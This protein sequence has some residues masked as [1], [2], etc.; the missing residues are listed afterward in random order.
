MY[1]MNTKNK[2]E[3]LT[4]HRDSI[5][6]PTVHIGSTICAFKTL[7]GYNWEDWED[8]LSYAKYVQEIASIKTILNKLLVQH[9]LISPIFMSLQDG[10]T[11]QP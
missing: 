5:L 8:P 3:T 2:E 6:Q 1:R 7:V 11:V 10:S 4:H 9:S